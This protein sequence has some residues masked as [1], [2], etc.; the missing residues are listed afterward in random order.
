MKLIM[1][2]NKSIRA[3][4]KEVFNFLY[5]AVNSPEFKLFPNCFRVVFHGRE[6]EFLLPG[7]FYAMETK[8]CIKI[9]GEEIDFLSW[10]QVR[11]IKQEIIFRLSKIVREEKVN[12]INKI[13]NLIK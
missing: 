11:K 6:I 13:F 8:F 9:D 1:L 5:A 3:K 2:Y 12:T 4:R 7:Y 10:F